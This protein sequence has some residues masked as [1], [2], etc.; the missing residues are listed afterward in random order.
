MKMPTISFCQRC[1]GRHACLP[2]LADKKVG[3]KIIEDNGTRPV[4]PRVPAWL[5][6]KTPIFLT[7]RLGGGYRRL[8]STY[9]C[10]ASY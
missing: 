8:F 7:G 9:P 2:T 4:V 3:A 6:Q 1:E 10:F 5:P